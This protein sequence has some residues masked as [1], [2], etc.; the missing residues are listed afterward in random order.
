MGKES[1]QKEIINNKKNRPPAL[2]F[3]EIRTRNMFFF[4]WPYDINS[5]TGLT[6]CSAIFCHIHY[7]LHIY[8]CKCTIYVCYHGANV[9]L[10]IL[11][12]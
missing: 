4:T 2:F 6:E 10:Y 9:K 7:T 8:C 11:R 1:M 12:N 3:I 5:I